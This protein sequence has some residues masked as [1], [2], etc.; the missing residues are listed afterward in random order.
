M[1][2]GAFPCSCIP[3]SR[4]DF[5]CFCDRFFNIFLNTGELPN[6]FPRD[7]LDAVI[8]EC[9]EKYQQMYKGSEPTVDELW[10]FFIERV[11]SNL[12]LSLCMSPV[13]V[14]L[15]RRAQMFPGLINGTTI[16]WFLTWPEEALT[17]VATYFIGSFDK[18]Q[19]DAAVRAKLIRHMGAVHAGM[20]GACETYFERYRRN[21]YVT[22]KSFLGFIEEYKGVY[23]KKLDLVQVLAD[24]INTGLEKL[25]EAAEDVEAI[26]IEVREKEKTLVVAQEKGAVM[27]Q[28]ITA[29][30]AKAEKKKAEANVIK[31][32]VASEAVI[33]G[34]QKDAVEEDLLAAKPALDEAE[35][36]LKAITAKDIG[37]LKQLKQPPDLVKRVFD[38]VLL[39]FQKDINPSAGRA[40]EPKHGGL[41]LVGSWNFSLPMMADIGFLPSLENFNKDAINDETVELLFPYLAGERHERRRRRARSPRRLRAC[42]RGRKAMALYVGIAKVVKPKMEALKSREQAE[43]R[44]HEARQGA[45]RAR[46]GRGRARRDAA[47]VRRGDGTK[48]ALQ[49][50]AEACQKKM[51]AAN[52]LIG[53]LAGERTRWEEQSASFADEIRRLAGDVALACAFITYVGPY[54]AEYRKQLHATSSSRPTA[55]PRACR[56]PRTLAS[57][58]SLSTRR[59]SATGRSRGCPRTTSRSRT[60]SW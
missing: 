44:Q 53:G 30:T 5:E 27:V 12:H 54:N 34:A 14:K 45:G 17:D 21:T 16:D 19:G 55:S 56:A 6:L 31:E 57:R 37:L 43:G 2:S 33:I 51:D 18:L 48:K 38:M 28:E 1:N 26:K 35:N 58:C 52:R 9:R 15:S 47:P 25:R 40:V 22:P 3:V 10:S 23:V 59:P 49:D 41:Q 36:A 50:D 29:S 60:A 42:A 20:N 24:S 8:G 39:L 4:S 11:R 7:E 46:P 13:G 32:S